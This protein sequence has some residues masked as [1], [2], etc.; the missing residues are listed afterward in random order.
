MCVS[1]QRFQLEDGHG[2]DLRVT[3]TPLWSLSDPS[4]SKYMVLYYELTIEILIIDK[5]ST[6]EDELNLF[7]QHMLK[8]KG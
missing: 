3:A 6:V 1:L 4:V 8:N 5:A 7:Y 2:C